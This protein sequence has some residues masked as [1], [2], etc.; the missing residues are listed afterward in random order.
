MTA[1]RNASGLGRGE[2][3]EEELRINNNSK[4]EE[5]V[6]NLSKWLFGWFERILTVMQREQHKSTVDSSSSSSNLASK[7][8]SKGGSSSN[9]AV[10][11]QTVGGGSGSSSSGSSHDNVITEIHSRYNS[12]FVSNRYAI[13]LQMEKIL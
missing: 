5:D 2:V 6:E 13:C 1:K 8:G 7:G 11:D 4:M 10:V 9:K 3:R 12:T